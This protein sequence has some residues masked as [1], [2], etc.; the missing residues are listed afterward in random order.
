[1]T[2]PLVKPPLRLSPYVRALPFRS[3]GVAK[4]AALAADVSLR[5][6]EEVKKT[7]YACL[8]EEPTAE[9]SEADTA[10]LLK[11]LEERFTVS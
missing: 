4:E 10:A 8:R 3:M 2:L 11:I 9:E 6:W 1:M 5:W 7:A